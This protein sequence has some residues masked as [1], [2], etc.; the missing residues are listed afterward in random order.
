MRKGSNIQPLARNK[1]NV[2]VFAQ[3]FRGLIHCFEEKSV[4]TISVAERRSYVLCLVR[5]LRIENPLFLE[6]VI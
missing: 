2:I 5:K 1:S 6:H 4:K 3:Q